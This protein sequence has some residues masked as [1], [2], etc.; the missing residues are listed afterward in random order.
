MLEQRRAFDEQLCELE[1]KLWAAVQDKHAEHTRRMQIE[2]S[3][4]AA[5][6]EL[7][8]L[9]S[10]LPY[11]ST[12]PLPS[13][14]SLAAAAA[15]GQAR[16]SPPPR[17]GGRGDGQ[18]SLDSAGAAETAAVWTKQYAADLQDSFDQAAAQAAAA[19]RE[20]DAHAAAQLR[21]LVHE[22]GLVRTALVETQGG[23]TDEIAGDKSRQAATSAALVA[24]AEAAAAEAAAAGGSTDRVRAE[25]VVQQDLSRSLKEQVRKLQESEDILRTQAEASQAAAA[26]ALADAQAAL[27]EKA[28]V[29]AEEQARAR[30][31]EKQTSAQL[32][33]MRE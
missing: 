8:R 26:A 31:Q 14:D 27:K 13:S 11:L 33:G 30:A 19:T 10:A 23:L 9:R 18:G 17:G 25:L 3:E 16:W 6:T 21:R 5:V 28:A 7:L 29:L 12:A 20:R 24:Q 15:S 4:K 32:A 2:V 1:E 22:L